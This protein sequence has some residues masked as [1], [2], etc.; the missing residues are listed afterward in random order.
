MKRFKRIFQVLMAVLLAFGT[1]GVAGKGLT[2]VSA[3]S[4]AQALPFSQDWTNIGLITESCGDPITHIYEIQGSGAASPIV[5]TSV[6][7]EGVVVGDFQVGGK[8]GYYI[9]DPNGDDVLATSDG[10][11]VYNTSVAVNVGDSVR[12]KGS[13]SE[14][15]T[16]T[17][18]DTLTELTPTSPEASNVIICPTGN[19]IVPTSVTLPVSAVS[20]F[21][22]YEGMLVTFPQDLII[23]EYY[24]FGRYGEIV[25]TSQ[26]RMTPTALVEPGAPAQAAAAAYLLDR[27]TLDDGRTS[28][29][30]DPAIGPNGLT[31]DLSNLFRGGD[32]VKDVTGILD[33]YQG[34]YRVQPTV[35][36]THTKA[37][38]R[39]TAPEITGAELK[40]ASFNVLNYFVTLDNDPT[41]DK[42]QPTDLCGP[43]G[44]QDCRGADDAGEF[45]RQKAKILAALTEID[46]D[47]FGLMEIEN[48]HPGGG[49]A[50]ADLVQGLN[51]ATAPSTYAYIQTG[52]IGGDAIK[53]A[54]LYKP[55]SVTPVGAYQLLTTTVDARFI[56]TVNRP[57]LAQGFKDNKTGAQF[58]V[59]VNHLKSKG[60]DCNAVG[61]PDTGDGAGNC[62]LTRKA[63]AQ[64]L[65]D[66][67]ANPS[68]F[69]GVQKTL[70][71]GDL[72]SYDKEDP[73]DMIKLGA[74]DTA[75][76][77]DD[78]KDMIFEKRGDEAYGY[79]FDGQIGYL[80]HA[81][82]NQQM[83]QDIV[84]VN[85]WHINADEPSLIDYDTSFKAAAQDAIYAP[86]AYRSSDHD[87]VIVTLTLKA[88][89]YLPLISK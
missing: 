2:V 17:G 58:V 30:P 27:I 85:F 28:Q 29:N 45:D 53:Q 10:I 44:G 88:V 75:G 63:A 1:L 62:N 65:V 77:A 82:A 26:R 13:V 3:D 8:K 72:N 56:D 48:E 22:K 64:A 47:I 74:D 23:S 9:Q 41:E 15:A 42:D 68:Y 43:L 87:P 36:G 11:F 18:G 61:D 81:L 19:P 66:W 38:P 84:D 51:A 59:A 34:L 55:A 35:G 24:N 73:I 76:T 21:E 37:N 89:L 14:Y 40:V 39:L 83:A 25:L 70:I 69:P 46:A 16:P 32:T 71:I 79:V 78:F 5:G 60:S 57:A 31:F 6:T 4:T 67:L 12:V 80:D 52:A 54:I 49:D 20:D 33:F 86:D 50:V 7:T